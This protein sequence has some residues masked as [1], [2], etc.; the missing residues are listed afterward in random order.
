MATNIQLRD[1]ATPSRDWY[2]NWLISHGYYG[3]V[4]VCAMHG[5]NPEEAYLTLK[6]QE[7]GKNML[8]GST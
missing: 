5:C 6:E 4:D 8:K 3:Y 1:R 2:L 7:D